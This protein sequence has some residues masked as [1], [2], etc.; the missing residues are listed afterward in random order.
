[1]ILKTADFKIKKTPAGYFSVYRVFDEKSVCLRSHL[2]DIKQATSYISW[3][4]NYINEHYPDVS[5]TLNLTP[6]PSCINK[7][8][9]VI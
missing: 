1:M 3:L 5:E 7:S 2:T 6:N 8:K 4:I 9:E